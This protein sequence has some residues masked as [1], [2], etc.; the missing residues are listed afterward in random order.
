MKT[1]LVYSLLFVSLSAATSAEAMRCGSVININNH[2]SQPVTVN[3][4]SRHGVPPQS[5][6][7]D[8]FQVAGDSSPS[9]WGTSN[10]YEIV[11]E[12]LA[13]TDVTVAAS[14]PGTIGAETNISW[15][16][17][18]TTLGAVSGQLNLAED[19]GEIDIR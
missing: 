15:R 7:P 19:R 4:E 17:P 2:T 18:S 8:K 10:Q 1:Q 9:T 13:T 16:Y 12:P 3:L 6:D 5:P 11:A 14:C